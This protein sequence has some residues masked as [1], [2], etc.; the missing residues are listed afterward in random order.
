MVFDLSGSIVNV[1]VRGTQAAGEY[2]TLW[3]GTNRPA[4]RWRAAS[5]FVRIV[6]PDIDEIRKVLVVR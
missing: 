6:G 1:L 2:E 4:R 5:Y 3:N